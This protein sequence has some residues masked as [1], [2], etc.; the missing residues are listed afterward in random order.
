MPQSYVEYSSGLTATTYSVPFNYL[1]I[2]DIKARG[3]NG[4]VWSDELT[5]ASRDSLNST[6]TLDAAPSSYS[7]LRLYRSSSTEQLVDFQKGSRLAERDLDAAYQ[8]GLFVALSLI[9][10]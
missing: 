10:I 1:S 6:I 7:K 9:H 5:I 4:S 2:D 3:Y 8:Q